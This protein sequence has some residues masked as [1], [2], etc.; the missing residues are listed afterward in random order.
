MGPSQVGMLS[1]RQLTGYLKNI[2][3]VSENSKDC[4]KPPKPELPI[5]PIVRYAK[6]CGINIPYE[7]HRDLLENGY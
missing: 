5:L 3:Y 4:G 7:I 2:R 6:R 1:L